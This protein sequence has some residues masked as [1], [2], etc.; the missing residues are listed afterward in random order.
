M[1]PAELARRLGVSRQAVSDLVRRGI[2]TPDANGRIDEAAARAAILSSVHP[3]SKTVQAAQASAPAPIAPVAA[4]PAPAPAA[5]PQPEAAATNY[6]VA[7]T[8]REA[9]E[10]HIARLKLAEMRGELI[11]TDAVRAV[12]SNI[13]ATT[14]EAVLQMPARLAP[15]LAA[16]SDPAAVQNLLHAELH[17]ALESLAN[18]PAA[19]EH[20]AAEPAQA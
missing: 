1:R 17:A 5:A 4:A 3:T 18:S 7:K 6:H 9:A 19:I 15:L 12:M 16:E 13:F 14:R 2:L 10:A 11:R 8:M 20:L